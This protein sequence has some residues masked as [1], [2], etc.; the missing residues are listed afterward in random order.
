MTV[1]LADFEGEWRLERRIVHDDG[2]RA[3]LQGMALFRRVP[4]GL[5]YEEVGRLMVPGQ[6]EMEARRA[7]LWQPDLTVW[8]EDG[9]FFHRV[10]GEG[11]ET[12]HWCDPDQ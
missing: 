6:P 2:T 4:E 11:G 5:A 8:F 1:E 10:P 7:Y 12:G 9:R 3:R